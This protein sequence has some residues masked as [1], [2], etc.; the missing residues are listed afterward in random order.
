MMSWLFGINKPPLVPS[1]PPRDDNSEN[2]G[3][4]IAPVYRSLDPLV[5]E[6]AAKAVRVLEK[7]RKSVDLT[8]EDNFGGTCG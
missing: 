1:R 2:E 4:R 6:R 7:S 3:V 8:S 5:L